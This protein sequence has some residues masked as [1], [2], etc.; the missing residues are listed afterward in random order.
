MRRFSIFW[1][2]AVGLVLTAMVAG[3]LLYFGRIFPWYTQTEEVA[4]QLAAERKRAAETAE[5]N[6]DTTY[7]GNN[8]RTVVPLS[9]ELKAAELLQIT[10][11][12]AADDSVILDIYE[13]E[14][15][16]KN[17][18]F[19]QGIA[20]DSSQGFPVSPIV[21]KMLRGELLTVRSSSWKIKVEPVTGI[22]PQTVFE[23][24]PVYAEWQSTGT[25][26]FYYHG[27]GEYIKLQ[28]TDAMDETVT[29]CGRCGC[30]NNS[31]EGY[32]V[33][34]YLGEDKSDS[35]NYPAGSV[36][37]YAVT[38]YA[39]PGQTWRAWVQDSDY[40]ERDAAVQE[41]MQRQRENYQGDPNG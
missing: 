31:D 29:I 10:I 15:R 6:N 5:K 37:G 30:Q 8:Q 26:S 38:V 33:G 2:V 18:R 27:P 14:A 32:G 3:Q 39:K 35:N 22:K 24:L 4:E 20:T 12:E 28:L 25:G 36:Q 1:S 7:S 23:N 17:S 9:S 21:L 19:S 34:I 40:D 41:E 11:L 16:S 13:D